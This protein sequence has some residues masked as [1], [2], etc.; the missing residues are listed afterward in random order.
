[1]HLK[2]IVELLIS[3]GADI[4]A[5]DIICQILKNCYYLRLFKFDYKNSFI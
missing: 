1:M 5:K 3:K 2:D 4:N